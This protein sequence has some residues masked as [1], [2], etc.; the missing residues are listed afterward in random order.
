MTDFPGADALLSFL[1]FTPIIAK[2]ALM[3]EN[4][5]ALTTKSGDEPQVDHIGIV[6][7]EDLNIYQSYT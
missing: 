6:S 3:Y 4:P 5:D 1:W 2:E 7:R